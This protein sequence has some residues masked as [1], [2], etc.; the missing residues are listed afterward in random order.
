MAKAHI[1][2]SALDLYAASGWPSISITAVPEAP[3]SRR[4]LWCTTTGRRKVCVARSTGF[5]VGDFT[6]EVEP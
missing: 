1:R 2:N 3:E 6:M 4:A 5:E